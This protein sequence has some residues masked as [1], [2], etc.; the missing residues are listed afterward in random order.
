MA[1]EY[2]V[3][4]KPADGD[5]PEWSGPLKERDAID[6]ITGIAGKPWRH[7]KGYRIRVTGD[8]LGHI[9]ELHELDTRLEH[10]LPRTVV[11]DKLF[12]VCL[13]NGS[14]IV[15]RTVRVD[16]N[17]K[18]AETIG[19]PD[20]DWIYGFLVEEFPREWVDWGIFNCRYIDGTDTVSQHAYKNALD[21]HPLTMVTGDRMYQA[22]EKVRNGKGQGKVGRVLWRV[23]SHFDHLHIEGDPEMHG[24]LDCTPFH[25]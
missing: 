19:T 4:L 21:A 20:V 22:L 16:T 8:E 2:Q 25:R 5:E 18:P 7:G 24:A 1:H 9:R 23:P 12:V 13:A 15:S 11:G 17:V 14:V 3:A 10:R 6:R